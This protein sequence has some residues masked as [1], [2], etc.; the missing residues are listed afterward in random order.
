MEPDDTAAD[1]DR[2]SGISLRELEVLQALVANGTAISAARRLD[3]SQS[4]VSRRLAQLEE[5]LG[6]KLFLRTNG[7]LI[8]TIEA[9]SLSE[10]LAPVLETLARLVHRA[11]RPQG[12]HEGTLSIVAPPTIAH[13]FLPSRIAAFKQANPGC[14]ITFD[15]LASDSLLTGIAE[16]RFDVGMSDS[17]VAHEG[18][19]SE[20]LLETQAIC[21]LPRDHHLA[22]FEVIRPEDLH[23]EP[24]IALSRRH[25]SRAA[26]DRL[27]DRAG[28]ALRIELEASTNVSVIQFVREG[29]GVSLLNPFPLVHQMADQVAMRPFLPAIR[30]STHFLLPASRAPSAVTRAFMQDVT[31]SLDRA[32]YP[33]PTALR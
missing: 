13:R 21:V 26:I 1:R 24:F 2:R 12:A 30:Y 17:T 14:Q 31:D 3:I 27:F 10:Q 22:A 25:S 9:L 19:T 23:D 4:A 8:P 15:V 18:I 28:L 7:R 11:D 29:L 6:F 16:G 32:A 5:R 20:L 33:T